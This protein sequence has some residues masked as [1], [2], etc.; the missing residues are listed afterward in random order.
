MDSNSIREQDSNED[1]NNM[2]NSPDSASVHKGKRKEKTGTSET[3]SMLPK[4]QKKTTVTPMGTRSNVWDHFTRT[5]EN[6]DKCDCNY[7]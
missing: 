6:K 7:C 4:P 2:A 1:A 5:E 3:K